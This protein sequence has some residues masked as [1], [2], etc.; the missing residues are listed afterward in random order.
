MKHWIKID[1]EGRLTSYADEGFHCG[2]GEIL[3]EIPA[4]FEPDKIRDYKYVQGAI[5]HDPLPPGEDINAPTMG[6]RVTELEAQNAMLMEC[7]LEMST[8]VYA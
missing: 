1:A 6:E 8:I 5:V 7:L 3:A 4:D 2:E